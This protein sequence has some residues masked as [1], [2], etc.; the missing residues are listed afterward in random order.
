MRD[1]A[2]QLLQIRCPIRISGP[3][4]GKVLGLLT[5]QRDLFRPTPLSTDGCLA[6]L[7]LN[8]RVEAAELIEGQEL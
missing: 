1:A 4:N 8:D 2:N 3:I 7:T 6:Q 5:G